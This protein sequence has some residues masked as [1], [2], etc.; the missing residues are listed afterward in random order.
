MTLGRWVV[1]AA[2]SDRLVSIGDNDGGFD[3]LLLKVMKEQ[4]WS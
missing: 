4:N 1:S 2:L 3:A